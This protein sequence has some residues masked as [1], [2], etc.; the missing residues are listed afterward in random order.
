MRPRWQFT[1]ERYINNLGIRK[2]RRMAAIGHFVRYCAASKCRLWGQERKRPE[3]HQTNA[4]DP[5]RSSAGPLML[6]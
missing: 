3:R 6:Q 4:R 5:E 1:I 2:G